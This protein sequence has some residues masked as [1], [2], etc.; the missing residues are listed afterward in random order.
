MPLWI[1][2]ILVLS[3]VIFLG[4]GANRFVVG[5]GAAAR[6]LG[7]PPLVIGM[8]V[9]GFATSLPEMIVAAIAAFHGRP[10]VGIGS[11]LGSNISNIGLVLGTTALISPV[12]VQSKVL[13]REFPMLLVVTIIA[14]FLLMDDN[15]SRAN[16]TLLFVGFILL[17]IWLVWEGLR[18]KDEPDA[19]SSEVTAEIP[20]GM[21]TWRA[22]VWIIVGLSLLIISSQMLVDGAVVIAEYFGLSELV[23]GLTVVAFG[24]S[25]P[26]L[27]TSIT[28]ALKGEHDLALGN[29]IGSNMF[30]LLGVMAL[31]G[32]IAPGPFPKI[33]LQFDYPVMFGLT[34]LLFVMAYGFRGKIGRINRLEGLLL[35]SC[36]ISYIA[37]LF[38]SST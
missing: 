18:K 29:V 14:F 26:E 8:A 10:E 1:A 23:I 25:L 6:N 4:I 9:L 17:F 11:A 20:T 37:Y 7:I 33:A 38:I 3:G 21:P 15:L 36:Y 24:T 34:V 12:V 19:M 31:P 16:G 35:I 13:K 5:A 32:L 28:S 30:N 2:V 22:V 27:A